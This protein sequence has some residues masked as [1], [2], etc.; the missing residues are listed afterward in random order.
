M[1]TE[2]NAAALARL[3]GSSPP[4][5][6]TDPK[7]ADII[8]ALRDIAYKVDALPGKGAVTPREAAAEM[9][10]GLF[11]VADADAPSDAT[12]APDGAAANA[13]AV[14]VALAAGATPEAALAAGD[15]AQRKAEYSGP[16]P[17][18]GQGANASVAGAK[19]TFGSAMNDAFGA[20]LSGGRDGDSYAATHNFGKNA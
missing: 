7:N 18:A 3:F 17:N 15:E 14:R 16:K 2:D 6:A 1:T 8:S 4:P 10:K 13:D 11:G 19:P 5:E 9:F 12:E 20:R